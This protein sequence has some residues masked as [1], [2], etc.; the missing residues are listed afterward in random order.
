MKLTTHILNSVYVDN[1][2]S[3]T[4]M[5]TNLFMPCTGKLYFTF[6]YCVRFE[7]L[8]VTVMKA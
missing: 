2:Q 1:T 4:S 6:Y 7:V 3:Y 8:T 5:T